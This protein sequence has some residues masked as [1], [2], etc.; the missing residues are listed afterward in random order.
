MRFQGNS[1]GSG[2]DSV[3]DEIERPIDFFP[4][5]IR[6]RDPYRAL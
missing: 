6:H 3:I 5:S 1:P 4:F 2:I